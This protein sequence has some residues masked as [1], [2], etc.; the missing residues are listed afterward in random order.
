MLGVLMYDDC[1]RAKLG[2]AS[3]VL[4][5]VR[6][7]EVSWTLR[8]WDSYIYDYFTNRVIVCTGR[9]KTDWWACGGCGS[10]R[11]TAPVV[12]ATLVDTVNARVRVDALPELGP[13]LRCHP[14]DG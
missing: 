10:Y 5:V 2:E 14:L 4:L 6:S 1:F 9:L 3:T 12:P 13:P 7:L 8:A 11:L